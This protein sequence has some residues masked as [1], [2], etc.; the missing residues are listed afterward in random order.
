[1]THSH[2]H[3]RS[4]QRVRARRPNATRLALVLAAAACALP[5]AEP[6][7][8]TAVLNLQSPHNVEQADLDGDLAVTE[9]PITSETDLSS[10]D[11][12]Y[13]DEHDS[14]AAFGGREAELRAAL[15]T[16]ELGV[17]VEKVAQPSALESLST[18]LGGYG[19]DAGF[20]GPA[21]L[22]AAGEN[23]PTFTGEGL[24]NGLP[25]TFSNVDRGSLDGARRRRTLSELP[26]GA[27]VLARDGA[28]RPFVATGSVGLGRFYVMGA[29]PLEIDA[30]TDDR[31]WAHNAIEFVGTPVAHPIPTPS[32]GA[33]MGLLAFVAIAARRRA[34][35]RPAAQLPS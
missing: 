3:P 2:P 4:E 35:S 26:D 7:R 10:F 25:V 13:V 19:T 21:A 30:K 20:T 18:V 28:D 16:G 34:R 5:F 11:V 31:A 17:V 15:Q 33:S 14:S 8:A 6:V 12:V 27:T 29:E 23:H 22:T 32:T 24:P 1:M 9:G